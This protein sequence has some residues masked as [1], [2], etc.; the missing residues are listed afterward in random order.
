M[1]EWY[2][3]LVAFGAGIVGASFGAATG[4]GALLTVPAL[5]LAGLSPAQA[6]GTSRLG[7][8]GISTS[9]LLAFHRAGQVDWALG[10][11][12]TAL[13]SVGALV[14][15]WSML[16]LPGIWV[17]KFIGAVILLILLLLILFPTAGLE[18]LDVDPKSWRYRSGY[19]FT[20]LLGGATGFY[21]GGGGT[22]AA[23]IMILCFGQTFLQSA[24]TR[25][26]P[27]LFSNGLALLVFL[28]HGQVRLLTGLALGVGA[29]IGGTL[30]SR[31]A[32]KKGNRWVRTAFLVVVGVIALRI[33]LF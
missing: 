27:F 20:F 7:S 29:F 28:Y 14:G 22:L 6:V 24:G 19:F 5:M 11:K 12:M 2:V 4:G 30:G 25:K 23:Y 10:W 16:Q 18:P 26:L 32:I 9:G 33:M 8:L 3:L 31:F 13:Q 17:K 21:Q 15:A 1:V